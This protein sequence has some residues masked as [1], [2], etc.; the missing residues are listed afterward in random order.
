MLKQGLTGES[1]IPE[2]QTRQP[3]N[4]QGPELLAGS[5]LEEFLPPDITKTRL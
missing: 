1:L 3:E 2:S 5:S 4:I